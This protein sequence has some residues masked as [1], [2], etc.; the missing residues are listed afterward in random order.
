[1]LRP[2]TTY[3]GQHIQGNIYRATYTGQHIQYSE[4]K[5]ILIKSLLHQQ[6]NN[7]Q[8][9]KY[10]ENTSA[11]SKQIMTRQHTNE[12][13]KAEP[14]KKVTPPTKKIKMSTNF[15]PI[16]SNKMKK[17]TWGNFIDVY[18]TLVAPI[19]VVIATRMDK[20]EGSYI[21]PMIRAFNEDDTGTLSNKWKILSFLSRKGN[22]SDVK[23]G[24]RNAMLKGED[25]TYEWEAIIGYVDR[26]RE[27]A[28]D[29]G[30]AIANA[31]SEFSKNDGQVKTKTLLPHNFP[32]FLS[33][34]F[35]IFT[36]II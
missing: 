22:D 29:V 20:T 13:S 32:L 25:S 17:S 35:C 2:S 11:A 21:T 4:F 7:P 18:E 36:H 19:V 28:Q 30:M 10:Y 27:T 31:F 24:K 34:N 12:S 14:K 33:Y 1:M 23:E 3:T 26:E 9:P 5:T 6:V 8:C 15:S 16:K